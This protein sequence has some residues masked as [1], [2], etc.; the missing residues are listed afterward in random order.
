MK[1]KNITVYDWFDI[2]AEICKKM[3]IKKDEFRDLKHSHGHFDTWC[4]QQGYGKK[5]P[6]GK[7]RGSSQIWFKEYN[8]S[9]TG[10][11]K[12][13][14]YVDL[15]HLALESVVP[16]NMHN[17]SIVTMFALED[18]EEEKEYYTKGVDWKEA[19][20]NAYNEVMLEIDPEYN[21]VSVS[22]SW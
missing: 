10:K 13:P 20:F 2:Q 11:V 1:S 5:D 3:G 12:C 16:D 19:F 14:P 22:F 18:Y 15:W 6:E 8:E 9:P 4:D 7:H 17:D 21:G